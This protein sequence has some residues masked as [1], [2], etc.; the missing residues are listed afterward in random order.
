MPGTQRVGYTRISTTDQ[1][2]ARQLADVDLDKLFADESSGAHTARPALAECLRYVREGDELVVHSMDRLARNLADLRR[3]VTELTDRGVTVTFHTERLTFGAVAN[4][5]NTLLLS[6][7]GAV[8]EFERSLIRER[9]R[10]GIAAAKQRG[11][12]KG[13]KPAMTPQRARMLREQFAAGRSARDLAIDFQVS[14]ETI[15]RYL[16]KH[17]S[18]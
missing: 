9:Q 10:E 4:P 11:V 3:M 7:I 13:R 1:N 14:P 16:R 2:P 8:A 17:E 6:V 5:M 12:Y 18:R 15:Y